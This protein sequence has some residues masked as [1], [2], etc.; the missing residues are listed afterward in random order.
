MFACVAADRLRSWRSLLHYLAERKSQRPHA[1]ARPLS[2]GL[3]TAETGSLL[4]PEP[5]RSPL[6]GELVRWLALIL[7]NLQAIVPSA[8]VRAAAPRWARAQRVSLQSRSPR[9][10]QKSTAEV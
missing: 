5:G 10:S 8:L 7:Q 6:K 3:H 9:G 1:M 4:L 2:G